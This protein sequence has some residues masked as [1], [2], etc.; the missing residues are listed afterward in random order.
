MEHVV[1]A[2]RASLGQNLIAVVLFGSQARH[3]ADEQSDWDLFVIATGLPSKAFDRHLFLKRSLPAS[4]R[5]IVSFLAKTPEEFEAHF[6]SLYL[7]IALDG[8]V[9]YD[10]QQ[11]V[12]K[13]LSRLRKIMGD[14]GLY[15]ERMDGALVWRWRQE[16]VS[17]WSIA[18][19]E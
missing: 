14:K 2:L 3:E 11:Y 15:R 19:G 5:G 7:D 4:C 16:P 17:P 10:P 6:S 1:E 12:S 9:L 18:W 13:L 8:K